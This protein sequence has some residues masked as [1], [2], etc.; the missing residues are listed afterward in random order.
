MAVNASEYDVS[1]HSSVSVLHV[2]DCAAALE[3]GVLVRAMRR[4]PRPHCVTQPNLLQCRPTVG[5]RMA[6][7]GQ[8]PLYNVR[9]RQLLPGDFCNHGLCLARPQ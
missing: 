3:Q 7:K 8:P 1:P 2:V 4:G 5:H 6:T 9:P